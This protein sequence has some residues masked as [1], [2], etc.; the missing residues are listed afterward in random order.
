MV[1]VN[2]NMQRSQKSQHGSC[3]WPGTY[4]VPGHLQLPWWCMLADLFVLGV[5]QCKGCTAWVFTLSMTSVSFQWKLEIV[6]Q[7]S[8]RIPRP[9]GEGGNGQWVD[10]NWTFFKITRQPFWK[11][12]S[13]QSLG[14]CLQPQRTC[15]WNLKLKFQSKL[16]L[17]C[18]NHAVQKPK[19]LIWPPGSHLENEVTENR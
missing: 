1:D 5:T 7:W 13:W 9:I 18:R 2:N 3:W 15:T 12:H 6:D 14:F 8:T 19:N 11:R 17:H 16:E 4:L 10:C